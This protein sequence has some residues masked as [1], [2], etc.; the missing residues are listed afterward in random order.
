MIPVPR[1]WGR[2]FSSAAPPATATFDWYVETEPAGIPL[3]FQWQLANVETFDPL[4]SAGE[5]TATSVTMDL[6][7]DRW[8]YYR[9]RARFTDRP[10][11]SAWSRNGVFVTRTCM[12]CH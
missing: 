8:W 2:E 12:D 4:F 7:L 5:T 9:V 10:N 11:F 3:T 6:P 1:L